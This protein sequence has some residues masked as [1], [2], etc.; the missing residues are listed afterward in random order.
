MVNIVN[1][2]VQNLK[3]SFSYVKHCN[4][5]EKRPR[6][7]QRSAT[8]MPPSGGGKGK[9]KGKEKAT[10]SSRGQITAFFK[11]P[12]SPKKPG[13]PP[14]ARFK[15]GRG[16]GRPAHEGLPLLT[17][18]GVETATERACVAPPPPEVGTST[19]GVARRV[20]QKGNKRTNY[21]KGEH[22]ELLKTA[23]HDWLQKTGEHLESNPTL[24]FKRYARLFKRYARV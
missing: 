20:H 16:L 24:G 13:R 5:S 17:G 23:A 12:P 21:S 9:G 10:T 8:T 1:G 6:S 15:Q 19:A 14:K 7:A 2:G 18:A 11:K 4:I 3:L 22:F